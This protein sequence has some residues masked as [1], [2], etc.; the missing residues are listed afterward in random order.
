MNPFTRF[1]TQWSRNASLADFIA[2]WD[3]LEK[4]VVQVHR[5]KITL[6]EARQEFE[7][8]WAWLRRHYGSWEEA[9]RPYWQQTK[10][11]GELTQT[12]PF[13]LLLSLEAPAAILGN[14]PAMQHLPAARE[15]LNLYLRDQQ[16]A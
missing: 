5:E 16:E 2:H 1:L 7:A 13:Q 15:A 14:W 12:D 4:L 10:A 9:L 11:A 6:L 8:V 3:R